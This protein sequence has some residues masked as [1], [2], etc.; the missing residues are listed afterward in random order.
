MRQ[1]SFNRKPE[2]RCPLEI[3]SGS[4]WTLAAMAS[5][6]RVFDKCNKFAVEFHR[7]ARDF[8]S[9]EAFSLPH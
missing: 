8:F 3:D 9:H 5:K 2:A 1:S 6:L 7:P 4:R